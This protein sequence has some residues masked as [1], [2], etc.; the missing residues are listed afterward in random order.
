[1]SAA[2]TLTK[3]APVKTTAARRR[4]NFIERSVTVAP[5]YIDQFDPSK[6]VAHSPVSTCH[7]TE[8]AARRV[9]A[10]R[11]VEMDSKKFCPGVDLWRSGVGHQ[12]V[13]P[14][15]GNRDFQFIARFQHARRDGHARRAP[16]HPEID[17]VQA[18]GGHDFHSSERE[19]VRSGA[20]QIFRWRRESRRVNGLAG[21]SPQAF[22]RRASRDKQSR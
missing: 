1:M 18:R 8:P 22:M 3:A 2:Q 6:P 20:R 7:S 9:G 13:D 15:V 5:S 12:P 4:E 16:D 17:A 10:C 14:Q 21:V 11:R 19:K